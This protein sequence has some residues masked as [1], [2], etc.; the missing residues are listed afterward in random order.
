VFQLL[1]KG[2]KFRFAHSNLVNDPTEGKS[3][4][5][6]LN[7]PIIERKGVSG[8]IGSFVE[9]STNDI[10]S[11]WR[12]YGN[13][14][15][16]VSFSVDVEVITKKS[17]KDETKEDAIQSKTINKL[18]R[19][20]YLDE[21]G[22]VLLEG[23]EHEELEEKLDEKLQNLK[24]LLEHITEGGIIKNKEALEPLVE[25]QYLFKNAIYKGEREV[26]YYELLPDD[27]SLIKWDDTQIPPT[28]YIEVE[29]NILPSIRNV[30]FGP[31]AKDA[32]SWIAWSKTKLAREGNDDVTVVQSKIPYR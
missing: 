9:P 3:L 31:K 12:A 26:R 22:N 11:L 23:E 13:D 30:T 14:G 25:I 29:N 1:S 19:I 5:N 6:F 21:N 24:E 7:L 4:Y 2:N 20:G 17:L 16:G 15:Q 8:F 27:Y 28:T 32:N 10:P 18:Y